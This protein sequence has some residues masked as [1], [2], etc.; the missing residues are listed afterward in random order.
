MPRPDQFTYPSDTHRDEHVVGKLHRLHPA[1]PKVY[2]RRICDDDRNYTPIQFTIPGT[3][4]TGA[5][6]PDWPADQQ[7]YF[8]SVF[9]NIGHHDD[10]THPNDGTP[11]GSDVTINVR[12]I[13]AD[14]STDGAVLASDSRVRVQP[15]EHKDSSNDDEDGEFTGTDLA[16]KKLYPHEVIYPYVVSVGSGR[17]GISM[18]VTVMLVPVPPGVRL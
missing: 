14:G 3:L 9:V 2:K 11:S 1:P 12:R 10:G 17:P 7:Y 4:T 8:H 13:T 18:V 15:N 6:T 16:I 5:K